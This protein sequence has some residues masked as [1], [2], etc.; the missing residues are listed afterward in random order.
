ME[1]YAKNI[2]KILVQLPFFKAS[3]EEIL[4]KEHITAHSTLAEVEKWMKH[5]QKEASAKDTL[6]WKANDACLEQR[7]D[8]MMAAHDEGIISPRTYASA[9]NAARNQT[10]VEVTMQCGDSSKKDAEGDSAK[11]HSSKEEITVQDASTSLP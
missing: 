7:V 5:K 1:S 4:R 9:E 10:P 6:N 3:E 2:E 11:K 8:K